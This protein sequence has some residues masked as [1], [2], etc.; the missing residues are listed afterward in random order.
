MEGEIQ[1]DHGWLTGYL[2]SA[3]QI[4][5]TKALLWIMASSWEFEH[6]AN[7]ASARGMCKWIE[8]EE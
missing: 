7:P 3:L 6:N 2:S 1:W 5:P 4:H 8:W